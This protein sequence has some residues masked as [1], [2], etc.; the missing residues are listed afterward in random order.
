M[1]A[2]VI[3]LQLSNGANSLIDAGACTIPDYEKWLLLNDFSFSLEND[4]ED[5]TAS[6]VTSS[7]QKPQA[8][9]VNKALDQSTVYL[10]HLA[11]QD[12]ST[13]ESE[14]DKRTAKITVLESKNFGSKDTRADKLYPTVQ[15]L[16]GSVRI[17]KW[18]INVQAESAAT[19]SFSLLFRQF[20]MVYSG[21]KIGSTSI[22]RFGPKS[23]DETERDDWSAGD[24]KWYV[25]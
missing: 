15:F 14:I 9:D 4:S 18:S 2:N 10:M 23:W 8:I 22:T 3:L 11:A 5:Y 16:L 20:S 7:P 13:K 1:I 6:E 25:R 12:R 19:E 24:G 21:Q 17:K